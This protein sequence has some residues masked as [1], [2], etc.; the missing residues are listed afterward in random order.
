[1]PR[2]IRFHLDENCA[3]SIAAGLRRRGI[4]LTTTPE[5]GLLGATDEEQLAFCLAE[6]R[7]IFSFDEDLLRLAA[8]GAEHVGIAYC[9]Q[10]RRRIGHIV[11]GLVL[12]WERLDPARWPARSSI[13]N[14]GK[15]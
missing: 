2:T 1:M 10:R 11:R 3:H 5:V 7:V 8:A 14:E 12:I 4:D 6:N 13:S 9:Q 15:R